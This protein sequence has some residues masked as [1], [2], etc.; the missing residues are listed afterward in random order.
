MFSFLKGIQ[1][2][3]MELLNLMDGEDISQQRLYVIMEL[4]CR[5][6]HGTMKTSKVPHYL[7]RRKDGTS[8]I[9][10]NRVEIRN[11]LDEFK[12]N[13]SSFI[14]SQLDTLHMNKRRDKAEL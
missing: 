4:C 11:M 7:L 2:E 13:V 14:S 5:Y 3:Y 12:A 8:S 10:I 1:D 6:S 9:G